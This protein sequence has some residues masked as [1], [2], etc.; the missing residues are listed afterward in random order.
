MDRDSEQITRFNT[1]LKRFKAAETK[2]KKQ[3]RKNRISQFMKNI[4]LDDWVE[5]AHIFFL[6]FQPSEQY[7]KY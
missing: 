1:E 6:F 5:M 2:K 3:Q 7:E 4:S